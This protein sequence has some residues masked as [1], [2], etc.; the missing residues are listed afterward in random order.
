MRQVRSCQVTVNI[1]PS[2]LEIVKLN[3][4][5]TSDYIRSLIVTDLKNK[6]LLTA[7]IT[8]KMMLG[9]DYETVIA[10]MKAINNVA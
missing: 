1:E 5:S 4:E 2:L 3:N 7:E 6:G 8:L 10:Q 9:D